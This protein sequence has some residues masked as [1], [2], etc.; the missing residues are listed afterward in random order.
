MPDRGLT[1]RQ[2]AGKR[3]FDLLVAVVGLLVGSPVVLLGWLSA[4]L[5]TRTNG[6]F[7]QVRI[8]LAW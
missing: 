4:T 6:F 2:A 8:G 3:G 1:R 7:R 5:E